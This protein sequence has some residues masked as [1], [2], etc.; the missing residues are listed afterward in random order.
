MAAQQAVLEA[1]RG[2]FGRAGKQLAEF[3]EQKVAID[4]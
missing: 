2:E 3:L 4:S 1:I